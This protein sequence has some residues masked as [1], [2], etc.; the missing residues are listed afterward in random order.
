[1]N[2]K[3]PLATGLLAGMAVG[4]G[5]GM[6]LAPRRGSETRTMLRG[7]ANR[8]KDGMSKG[9]KRAS[10]SVNDWTHRGQGVYKNTRDKVAQGAKETGRYMREVADAVT[11][12]SRRV[13]ESPVRRPTMATATGQSHDTRHKSF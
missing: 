6:L 12:K 13:G 5:V 3:H 7:H 2:N 8:Y 9:Y 1:M 4:A 10:S 11:R